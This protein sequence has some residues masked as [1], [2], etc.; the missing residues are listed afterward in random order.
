MVQQSEQEMQTLLAQVAALRKLISKKKPLIP[1]KG[2]A[3]SHADALI[4]MPIQYIY[5]FVAIHNYS[6]LNVKDASRYCADETPSCFIIIL[7]SKYN[8][9]IY[10]IH[11]MHTKTF[12]TEYI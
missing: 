3:H 2:T 12:I 6:H 5:I 10:N 11:N 8:C 9:K 1:E 7:Y 4:Q